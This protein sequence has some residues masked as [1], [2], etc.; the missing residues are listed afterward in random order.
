MDKQVM[1]LQNDDGETLEVWTTPNG[2]C[3]LALR[4]YQGKNDDPKPDFYPFCLVLTKPQMR[5]L[6]QM[7][8]KECEE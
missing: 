4:G 5:D 6:A 3:A 7:L 8:L 2:N 1:D